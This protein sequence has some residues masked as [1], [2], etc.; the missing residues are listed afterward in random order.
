MRAAVPRTAEANSYPGAHSGSGSS[1]YN[2]F[3]FLDFRVRV[4]AS[5]EGAVVSPVTEAITAAVAR[6]GGR[7]LGGAAVFVP[8]L[9]RFRTETTLQVQ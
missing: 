3:R 6:S 1:Y 7:A 4:S 8:L 9:E 2:G 5:Q